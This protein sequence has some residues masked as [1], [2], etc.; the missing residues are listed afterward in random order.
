[1]LSALDT[2]DLALLTL[3]DLSAALDT[4]NHHILLQRLT[5]TYSVNGQF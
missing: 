1:M 3:I 5:T 2:G 4:V